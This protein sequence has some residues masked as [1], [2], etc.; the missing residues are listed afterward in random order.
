MTPGTAEITVRVTCAS[1]GLDASAS[2]V[3]TVKAPLRIATSHV[4]VPRM[5]NL[6]ISPESSRNPD[7]TLPSVVGLVSI[8]AGG[9]VVS[10][11]A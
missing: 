8:E 3:L 9:H 10:H 11:N 1:I 6:T 5:S 7:P 2:V 4:L